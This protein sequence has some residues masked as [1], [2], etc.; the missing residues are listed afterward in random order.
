M[1]TSTPKKRGRGRPTLDRSEPPPPCSKCGHP[2]K[3]STSVDKRS[4]LARAY[5]KHCV[6]QSCASKAQRAYDQHKHGKPAGICKKHGIEMKW[7]VAPTNLIRR[8]PMCRKEARARRVTELEKSGVRSGDRA[9]KCKTCGHWKVWRLGKRAETIC[10]NCMTGTW[11]RARPSTGGGSYKYRCYKRAA[12][13]RGYDWQISTDQ[14]EMLVSGS[15]CYC[16][17]SDSAAEYGMGL[18]RWDNSRGY[19]PDNVVACC[20]DCNR[21]KV[22]RPPREFVEGC[23]AIAAQHG[24]ILSPTLDP[25]VNPLGYKMDWDAGTSDDGGGK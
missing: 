7:V 15:C 21:A 13:K 11:R 8:C 18:D 12:S 23:R 2:R 17:R 4:G 6:R 20:M 25:I 10:T 3:W 19:L 14:F 24:A 16:G 5:C 22:T 1:D 9:W